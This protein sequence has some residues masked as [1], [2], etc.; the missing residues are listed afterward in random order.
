MFSDYYF[1]P[2]LKTSSVQEVP[3]IV[4]DSEDEEFE[5]SELSPV[6]AYMDD[7]DDPQDS[8]MNNTIV[9]SLMQALE[10]NEVGEEEKSLEF[11]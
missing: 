2:L 11:E 10:G 6:I 9:N 8:F 5:L 1:V 4:E 3:C 7:D